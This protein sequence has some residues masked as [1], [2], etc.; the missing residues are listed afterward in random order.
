M[1]TFTPIQHLHVPTAELTAWPLPD[2]LVLEGSPQACGAVLSKAEDLRKVSGIWACTPGRFRWNWTYD[3][4]VFMLS[5][6][7]TVE[8]R[9]GRRVELA[10]G[11]IAFFGNG[12]E[13]VWTIHEP[14]R[15]AFHA[16]A[17]Q[18]LPF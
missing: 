6:H 8:L 9:G 2:D 10:P 7:A 11:D 14:L 16:D 1:S 18:P 3:E 13:S 15:K 4:T 5:G 12:E 17:P